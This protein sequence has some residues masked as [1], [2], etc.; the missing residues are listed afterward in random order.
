VDDVQPPAR[1]RLY[2]ATAVQ[3]YVLEE[4]DLRVPVVL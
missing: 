4:H 1:H 2:R 3:Q